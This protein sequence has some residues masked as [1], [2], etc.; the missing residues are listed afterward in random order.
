[1]AH[2]R[3]FGVLGIVLSVQIQ[4][5]RKNELLEKENMELKEEITQ[6]K[7]RCS[8]LQVH[9]PLAIFLFN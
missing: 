3:L 2:I 7:S 9:V 8:E 4:A 1:M 5:E 6:L